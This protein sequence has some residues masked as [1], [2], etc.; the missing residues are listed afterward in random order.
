MLLTGC[1]MNKL[2]MEA[3]GLVKKELAGK[4]DMNID[5]EIMSFEAPKPRESELAPGSMMLAQCEST[6]GG[7][8]SAGDSSCAAVCPLTSETS[9]RL[10]SFMSAAAL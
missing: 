5:G 7:I 8:A 2:K 6:S 1:D 10:S 3:S 9:F 4:S